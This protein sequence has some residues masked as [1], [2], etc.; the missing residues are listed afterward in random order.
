MKYCLKLRL[1]SIKA[2]HIFPIF[3]K[4]LFAWNAPAKS[5]SPAQHKCVESRSLRDLLSLFLFHYMFYFP[6]NWEWGRELSHNFPVL[7]VNYWHHQISLASFADVFSNE[8]VL[9]AALKS[10]TMEKKLAYI[11]VC[12]GVPIC[13]L[14]GRGKYDS[15]AIPVEE[16]PDIR[17]AILTWS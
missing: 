8:V 11:F 16:C 17:S 7:H 4:F 14:M 10:T 3:L 12:L 1:N 15:W 9:Y 2:E 6:E 5:M 13:Q